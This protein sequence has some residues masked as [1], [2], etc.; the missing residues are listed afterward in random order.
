MYDLYSDRARFINVYGPTECTCICS[1]YEIGIDNFDDYTELSSLGKINQNF[2]YLI[3]DD[4][5]NECLLGE[6]CLLGPNVGVGYFNDNNRTKE[7]FDLFTNKNHYM[8]KRYKTGDIVEKK[9]GLLFFKGRED[10][11]IKHMGYRIEL[12][13]IEFALNGLA[14]IEQSAV[15][16]KR[17][18]SAY[19]KIIAFVASSNMKIND[20]KIKDE[21]KQALPSYMIPNIINIL[22]TLPKNQNGKVDKKSLSNDV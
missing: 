16:Y 19:G 22:D 7:S 20:N 8:K 18:K 15:I 5:G 1:S 13:E 14:E 9:D 21:L 12:E 10:N 4:N 3:L 11:Q 6:L 17:T 2:S